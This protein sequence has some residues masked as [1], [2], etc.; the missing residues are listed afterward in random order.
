MKK[1]FNKIKSFRNKDPDI[2]LDAILAGDINTLQL[3]N[4]QGR[5]SRQDIQWGFGQAVFQENLELVQYFVSLGANIRGNDHY[6]IITASDQGNLEL[7][8]YLISLGESPWTRNDSAILTAAGKGHLE[9]VKY[10][11]S[12][13]ASAQFALFEASRTNRLEIVQY[14]I[15]NGGVSRIQINTALEEAIRH[16]RVDIVRYLILQDLAYY[17][18]LPNYRDAAEFLLDEMNL[19]RNIRPANENMPYDDL[20]G[21][22]LLEFLYPPESIHYFKRN[23]SHRKSP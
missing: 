22:Y 13:G 7:V 1:F 16:R 3:L 4:E 19:T 18:T 12:V 6:A 9:V 23:K 15:L 11:L 21:D 5:I 8:Q 10:L 14:L 20:W 17:L 2:F